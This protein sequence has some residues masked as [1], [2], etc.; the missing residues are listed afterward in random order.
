MNDLEVVMKDLAQSMTVMNYDY[1]NF[2]KET[3]KRLDAH[4]EILQKRVYITSGKARTLQEKV[5]EKVK[6]ICDENR[7]NYKTTKSKIFPRVWSK[8]KAK[9]DVANYRELP[10]LFWK[11][12][13]EY[14]N[15][16]TVYV[17]DI[18]EEEI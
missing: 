15:D 13:L 16:M 1:A 9:Y 11:E 10:E 6:E 8:I 12:I 7:L 5:K 18:V 4:D 3:S 17:G 2:K 14:L